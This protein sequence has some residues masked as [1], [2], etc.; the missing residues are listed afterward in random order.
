MSAAMNLEIIRLLHE[1]VLYTIRL[2]ICLVNE[3]LSF[4]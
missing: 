1:V 2:S 3:V 4:D